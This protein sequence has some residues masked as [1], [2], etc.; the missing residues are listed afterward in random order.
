MCHKE[1]IP[2]R[3]Q[4]LSNKGFISQT[5]S[6][7]RVSV[8]RPYVTTQLDCVGSSEVSRPNQVRLATKQY[9]PRS[10]PPDRICDTKRV[11]IFRNVVQ[12]SD[13]M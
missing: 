3:K 2:I 10:Q 8:V 5:V 6:A 7:A 13:F 9:S 4:S 12:Q 11:Y 1:I